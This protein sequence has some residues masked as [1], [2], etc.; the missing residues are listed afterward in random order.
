L[1]FPEKGWK[2]SLFMPARRLSSLLVLIPFLL[3]A[4]RDSKVETY[5]IPKENDDGPPASAPADA[6]TGNAP[7]AGPSLTWAAPAD[8][9]AKPA[10]AMRK[11]SFAVPGE[12][13]A[14]ADL[15]ISAFPGDVGG[16]L[17]NVNR[18]RGQV[19]L[20]PLGD[21]DLAGAVTRLS[22]DGL[23]FAV[24]D[25]AG[26]G[27]RLLG[28]IIPFGNG[29]WFVKLIGPEALVAARKPAFLAFLQTVKPAGGQ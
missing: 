21:A 18:W 15:S 17:A 23:S 11:G 28:A 14:E 13:G 16:E 3:A 1:E 7:A 8:W 10:T 12:G 5:R 4:C 29:T 24:V 9:K 20:P 22:H 6:D 19:G 25:C 27:K 2:L 26:A